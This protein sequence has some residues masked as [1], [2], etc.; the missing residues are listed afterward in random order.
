LSL[1]TFHKQQK[2]K[3][4]ISERSSS[5]TLGTRE[6]Q[7]CSGFIESTCVHGPSLVLLVLQSQSRVAQLTNFAVESPS[8]QDLLQLHSFLSSSSLN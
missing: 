5:L 4:T 6:L 8:L 1:S 7:V 3:K 2:Q